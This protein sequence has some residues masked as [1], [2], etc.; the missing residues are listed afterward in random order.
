M[1]NKINITFEELLNKYNEA[2][3]LTQ[4]EQAPATATTVPAT[5]QTDD[6]PWEWNMKQLVG[7]LRYAG[8][9]A[10]GLRGG[11]PKEGME[12]I[13]KVMDDLLEIGD[14]LKQYITEEDEVEELPIETPEETEVPEET[15]VEQEK[16]FKI[17]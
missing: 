5:T 15:D 8:A 1:K 12:V 3:E 6:E 4:G 17:K 14:E 13:K 7:I 2:E 9:M 11:T 16:K 10:S